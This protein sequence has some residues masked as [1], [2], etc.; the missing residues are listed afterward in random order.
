[1][2]NKVAFGESS[3]RELYSGCC[4]GSHAEMD[5][6]RKLPTSKNKRKISIDLIVI[7]VAKNGLLKNSAPCSKCLDHMQKLCLTTAYKIK[8]IYYSEADGT[9]VKTKF[10]QL[11]NSESKHISG[12]FRK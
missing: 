7:R 4:Y 8:Y 10:A 6:I 2:K 11:L 5:A 3:C 1:M 12:R 9:L